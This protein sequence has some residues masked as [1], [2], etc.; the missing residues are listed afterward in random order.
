VGGDPHH[1]SLEKAPIIPQDVST[2]DTNGGTVRITRRVEITVETDRVWVIRG[3]QSH[4]SQCPGCNEQVR[5]IDVARAA[6]LVRASQRQI[7]RWIE[8]GQLHFVE[9]PGVPLLVCLTSL[10]ERI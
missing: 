8:N 4:L 2:S 5:M 9:A 6:D 1:L 10:L 3:H 7:F